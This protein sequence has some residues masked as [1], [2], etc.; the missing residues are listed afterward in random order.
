MCPNLGH[1]NVRLNDLF[2]VPDFVD[3]EFALVGRGHDRD[4]VPAVVGVVGVVVV[5]ARMK[6]Q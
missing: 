2:R 5:D 4:H 3:L 1:S 6:K